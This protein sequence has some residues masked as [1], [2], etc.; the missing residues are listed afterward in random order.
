M[1]RKTVLNNL[2]IIYNIYSHLNY[3]NI[4]KKKVVNYS[5]NLREKIKIN[6]LSDNES[7]FKFF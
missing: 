6:Q 2:K 7:V 1:K 4:C 5:Q 3:L